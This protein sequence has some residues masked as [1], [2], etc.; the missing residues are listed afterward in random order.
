MLH[1]VKNENKSK[2]HDQDVQSNLQSL[3]APCH[4]NEALLLWITFCHF[5]KL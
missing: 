1:L 4:G 2:M 5:P 3:L